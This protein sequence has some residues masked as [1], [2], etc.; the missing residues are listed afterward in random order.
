MDNETHAG[1]SNLQETQC[2]LM[3]DRPNHV[4]TSG[5][6]CFPDRSFPTERRS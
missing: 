3:S 2:G 1:Q 5:I 6:V 4:P